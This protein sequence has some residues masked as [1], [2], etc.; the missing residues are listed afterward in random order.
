MCSLVLV[1]GKCSIMIS[2]SD[3]LLPSNHFCCVPNFHQKNFQCLSVVSLDDSFV[4]VSTEQ[5]LVN[6]ISFLYPFSSQVT[7]VHA[8]WGRHGGST[9]DNLKSEGLSAEQPY[10]HLTLPPP[11]FL[12]RVTKV[13]IMGAQRVGFQAGMHVSLNALINYFLCPRRPSPIP[14][15]HPITEMFSWVTM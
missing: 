11:M 3:K 13:Q 10:P 15:L 1:N 6:R 9:H 2:A 4:A 5:K 12:P 14:R 7:D 8:V